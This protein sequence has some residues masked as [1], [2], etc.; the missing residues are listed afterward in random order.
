M[1]NGTCARDKRWRRS[2]RRTCSTKPCASPRVARFG[3]RQLGYAVS[4][5]TRAG[6]QTPAT[7]LRELV[8]DGIHARW[9]E[10]ASLPKRA[11][12]REL[13][14]KELALIAR[15]RYES[16][17]L[18]VHDIVRFARSR[19]NPVPGAR[20]GGQL[21]GVL[22]PG[23]HRDRAGRMEMLF[24]RFLSEERNEPPDIDV[25]FEHERREEV[26]QYV[27]ERYG[28]GRAALAASG[29]PLSRAQRGARRGTRAGV[30]DGPGRRAG[31]DDGSL[32]QR[33]SDAGALA[34]TRVR[35]GVAACC[36]ACCRSRGTARVPAPPVAASGRLRDFRT[37]A[38]DAR[39][40]GKRGDGRPHGDPVGQGRPG[41]R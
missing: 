41:R 24:E 23:D 34:R 38:V 10:G 28:R 25:D 17:F 31:A 26:F 3:L 14:E 27:F 39:A 36:G 2:I 4:A 7:W 20:L 29:H 12:A 21:G 5:R 22:R 1:A 9:A 37:S 16:Y 8:E 30:A 11:K 40:G 32:E 18:T 35:P 15:A 19:T 33:R 13:I 6:G